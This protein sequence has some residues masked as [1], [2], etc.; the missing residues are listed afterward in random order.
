[1]AVAFALAWPLAPRS[2]NVIDPMTLTGL[3]CMGLELLELPGSM[4]IDMRRGGKRLLNQSILLT[5]IIISPYHSGEREKL[6][7]SGVFPNAV[8]K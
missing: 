8:I 4:I 5:I 7:G 3:E 2:H 1:M 6:S